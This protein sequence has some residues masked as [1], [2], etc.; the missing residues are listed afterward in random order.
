MSGNNQSELT[1]PEN[2]RGKRVRQRSYVVGRCVQICERDPHSFDNSRE[3]IDH[4]SY[5]G[6]EYTYYYSTIKK[7]QT[8]QGKSFNVVA[9]ISDILEELG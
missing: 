2:R 7:L 8:T 6:Y 1:S 3:D 9:K 4:R 5:L